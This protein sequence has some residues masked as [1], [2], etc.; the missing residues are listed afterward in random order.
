MT[1]RRLTREE[2]LFCGGSSGAAVAGA[3]EYARARQ[4]GK[5]SLVVVLLPDAG[6]I[7][8][9]K[10]YSDEWMR[11]NQFLGKSARVSDI[12]ESKRRKVPELLSAE[13]TSTV[14]EA[15]NTMNRFAVSQ[16]PVFEKGNLVGSLCESTLFQRSME[17]PEVMELSV[18]A[19]LEPPFPTVG[20]DEDVYEVVQLLKSAPAVLVRDTE[21][22]HGI[23]TRFDVVG[24]LGGQP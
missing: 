7:Y 13:L 11:Q 3:L 20:A 4:L 23:L 17:T 6:E 10:M 14:R 19:L 12:L 16:L 22:Y 9:S 21:K 5:D 8:L 18:G 24:H 1:G 2:G 15:I